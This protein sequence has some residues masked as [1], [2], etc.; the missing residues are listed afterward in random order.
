MSTLHKYE[1][2]PRPIATQ[3]LSESRRSDEVQ[4]VKKG[5]R[6]FLLKE[7][8]QDHLT[9][10]Q[11]TRGFRRSTGTFTVYGSLQSTNRGL[12][13][14]YRGGWEARKGRWNCSID[15]VKK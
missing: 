13:T 10:L 9:R 7:G 14:Y 8:M 4:R 1:V 15:F 12:V 5:Q 3:I 11:I 6:H 2:S